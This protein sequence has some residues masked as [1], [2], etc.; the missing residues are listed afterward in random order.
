MVSGQDGKGAVLVVDD[1]REIAEGLATGLGRVG[2]EA[3]WT[4]EPR[5]ALDLAQ[6]RDFDVAIVDLVMPELD[7]ISLVGRLG[8]VAPRVKCIVLTGRDDVQTCAR[9]FKPGC[10]GYLVKPF[11]LDTVLEAI[12]EAR[13]EWLG[14]T[15]ATARSLDVFHVEVERHYLE[16]ASRACRGE[17]KA[18]ARL[19]GRSL[20]ATYRL[21]E[22]HGV[23]FTRS[24]RPW[25]WR[26]REN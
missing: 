6:E 21:L 12:D 1:M 17:P 26:K 9:C 14:A 5:E 23:T 11:R 2:Y 10:V 25:R 19:S 24:L 8:R 4:T 22:K 13:T 3:A 15:S 7:G 16:Q 20:G 18:I